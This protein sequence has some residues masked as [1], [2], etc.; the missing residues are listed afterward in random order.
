[1]KKTFVLFLLF[2]LLI[3]PAFTFA[4]Q[5]CCSWHWWVSNQCYNGR[6]VCNDGTYSPSCTCWVQYYESKPKY[7][8]KVINDSTCKQ[9]YWENSILSE[10][11]DSCTCKTWYTRN[12][13]KTLCVTCESKFW[14]WAISDGYNCKCKEWY[15]SDGGSCILIDK[16][17]KK[18]YWYNS[19]SYNEWCMCENWYNRDSQGNECVKKKRYKKDNNKYKSLPYM[20]KYLS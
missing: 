1:M 16:A 17:C 14:N 9:K 19:I 4:K 8:K 6:Q 20:S 11:K 3:A 2:W 12:I 15:V 10:R 13:S 18:E 5:W 7:Y